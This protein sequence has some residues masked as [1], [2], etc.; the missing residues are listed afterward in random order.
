[1]PSRFKNW[2]VVLTSL[3]KSPYLLYYNPLKF[4][5]LSWDVAFYYFRYHI[6]VVYFPFYFY[7]VCF[8]LFAFLYF[9]IWW[10]TQALYEPFLITRE[11]CF[12]LWSKLLYRNKL[13]SISVSSHYA[14]NIQLMSGLYHYIIPIA[15][16]DETYLLYT[17]FSAC[18]RDS[19]HLQWGN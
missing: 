11:N 1:M 18:T 3:H 2:P 10:F 15:L 16:A 5:W 14:S 9:C 13:I 12:K 7:V 4:N 19:V 8:T 6:L 17:M